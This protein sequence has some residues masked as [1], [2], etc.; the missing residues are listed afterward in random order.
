MVE[1]SGGVTVEIQRT[2]VWK[3]GR[4]ADRDE[5]PGTASI[6]RQVRHKGCRFVLRGWKV[7][8]TPGEKSV[9]EATYD[10]ED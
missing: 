4:P 6:Q 3:N 2:F 8:Y 10:E 9:T 7:R 5:M 1:K